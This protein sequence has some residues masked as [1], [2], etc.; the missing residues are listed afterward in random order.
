MSQ[1][2]SDIK[3]ALEQ[4]KARAQKLQTQVTMTTRKMT[5]RRKIV[6]G[7]MLEKL[8]LTD[9]NAKM[10]LDQIQGEI[11]KSTPELLQ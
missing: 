9:T 7:A 4:A 3:K 6:V 1:K 8:A 10:V 11:R 2:L 5:T